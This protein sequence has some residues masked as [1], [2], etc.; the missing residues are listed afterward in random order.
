MTRR[1]ARGTP[2][3]VPASV[4]AVTGIALAGIVLAGCSSS[5]AP[6]GPS[7][8]APSTSPPSTASAAP[9]SQ[10][11][12]ATAP[13]STRPAARGTARVA[14]TLATGLA[15]PWGI[16]FLPGGDALVGERDSAR[17]L[18]VGAQGG[19]RT[20]GRVPGVVSNGAS[21]GEGGLLGLAVSPTYATDHLVFAY[22]ST[23]SDNRVVRMTYAN[24]LL[25]TPVPVLTG[26]PHG[27]HH[28]GG[29]L[30]F[31]PDRMLYA[32]PASRGDRSLAQDLH[33][34]GGKVLRMTP[35]GTPPG[36]PVPRLAG[37]VATGTE[38]SRGW[39]STP[40]AGSGPRSSAR[41]RTTSST[42][43]S[44]GHNYGWPE[45]QGRTTNPLHEP[46]GA[47]GRPTTR[48]RRDRAQ[49][50]GV[51]DGGAPPA[52]ACTGCGS[53][54]PTGARD[55]VLVGAYGRIRLAAGARTARSG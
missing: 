30:V 11:P 2:G 42:W 12:S 20:V 23:G 36:Q 18:L 4:L 24:G 17:V 1:R 46:E 21:G 51:V 52:P 32:R 22:L 5:S 53:D 28:N 27:L 7:G 48:A 37:L 8:S 35:A 9:S 41:R 6:S 34:L 45:T 50:A 29:D 19:A 39:R 43:Y 13:T 15:V 55:P 33:S 16:T 54:G 25:G 26:I 14:G 3:R 10:S 38:T 44:P 47:S 40:P 49:R 31:G